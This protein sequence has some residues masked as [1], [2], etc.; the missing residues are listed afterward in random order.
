MIGSS[1]ELL[2]PSFSACLNEAAMKASELQL[3][4]A[5]LRKALEFDARVRRAYGFAQKRN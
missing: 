3:S 4:M 5:Q 1:I 2:W